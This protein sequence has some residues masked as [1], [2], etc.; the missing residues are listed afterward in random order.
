MNLGTYGTPARLNL[1]HAGMRLELAPDGNIRGVLGGYQDWHVIASRY[2]SSAAEQVHNF[3]VPGLYNALKR[4]A[5]GL[6]DPVT[7]E[8]NGISSAFDIEGIP[9]FIGPPKPVV[10]EGASKPPK[11]AGTNTYGRSAP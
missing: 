9:A 4:D 8:C 2:T 5:D 6:K 1:F 3:Q 11:V 10:V 7:G